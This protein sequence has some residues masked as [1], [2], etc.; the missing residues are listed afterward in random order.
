M[1]P[2]TILYFKPFRF[3]DGRTLPKN[4]YF[5]V[6]A[7][8]GNEA[9]L[10]SLPTSQDHL[11]NSLAK[12]H[13]CIESPPENGFSAYVFIA[14]T[15]ICSNGWAFPK[16]MFIYG[17][18]IANFSI[19]D[20]RLKQEGTENKGVCTREELRSLLLCLAHGVNVKRKWRAIFLQA[21]EK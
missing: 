3:S 17:E 5:L 16:D 1:Q 19:A 12:Q 8:V 10:A 18:Q 9:L 14:G 15:A 7:T 6:L 11:P 4:K 2:G 21:L 13:G 20:P